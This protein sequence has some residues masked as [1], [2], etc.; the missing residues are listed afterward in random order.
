M[1]PRKNFLHKIFLLLCAAVSFGGLLALLWLLSPSARISPEREFFALENS[2]DIPAEGIS[3]EPGISLY[4]NL[5]GNGIAFQAHDRP[6]ILVTF[7]LCTHSVY[8]HP[9]Y[10][11]AYDENGARLRI[12]DEIRT[13]GSRQFKNSMPHGGWITVFI[14]ENTEQVFYVVEITEHDLRRYDVIPDGWR[15]HRNW[16]EWIP[17]HEI[18]ERIYLNGE[19]YLAL[20]PTPTPAPCFDPQNFT[21]WW[22]GVL[23]IGSCFSDRYQFNE[24]GTFIFIVSNMDGATRERAFSGSWERTNG[25]VALTVKNRIDLVGGSYSPAW[26]SF[27]SDYVIDGGTRVYTAL[28]EENFFVRLYE[29]SDVFIDS[30]DCFD[31]PIQI[32]SIFINGRQ[33]WNIGK[34]SEMFDAY[35]NWRVDNGR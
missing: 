27:G 26:G 3:A 25:Q 34:Q 6:D 4:I 1:K 8:H 22:H 18:A 10:E 29:I 15:G 2:M 24:D 16:N 19:E 12:A 7:E 5:R 23:G 31:P 13:T 32:P 11:F 28:E 14:P 9:V 35:Y 21:G 30:P 33:F 20:R 17:L